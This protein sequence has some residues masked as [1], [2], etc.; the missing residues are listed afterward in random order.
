MKAFENQIGPIVELLKSLGRKAR[1]R[2]AQQLLALLNQSIGTQKANAL[3]VY[4]AYRLLLG[5]APD[6]QGFEHQLKR[7]AQ[8]KLDSTEVANDLLSSEEFRNRSFK[9]DEVNEPELISLHDFSIF[10]DAQ[11]EGIGGHLKRHKSYEPAVTRVLQTFLLEGTTF[12]DV[13]ANLGYF[14]L[15]AST[16]VGP[17]GKVISIEAMPGNAALLK[18]TVAHNKRANIT[19]HAVAAGDKTGVIH[20]VQPDRKN[21]GSPVMRDE[22]GPEGVEVPLVKLDDLVAAEHVSVVKMDIEGAEG[23]ALCGLLETLKR[24]HP[25]I[26]LE[27]TPT[28]LPQV[29]KMT[30]PHL[31]Q[32]LTNLG[33]LVQRVERFAG[34]F[35]PE[36][37]AHIIQLAENDARGHLDL[38]FVRPLTK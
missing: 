38:L 4:F 14:S 16:L 31:I 7:I 19:V 6:P 34:H 12:L 27:Y 26:V 11:D 8:L 35:V 15:L 32:M 20:M 36:S 5:R 21:S 23:L 28:R 9:S 18:K 2:S 37:V 3:D 17:G 10:V 29:S 22:R 25:I 1:S 24:N 30:G 13:G 33:Y